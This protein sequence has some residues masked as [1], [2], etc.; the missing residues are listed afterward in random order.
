MEDSVDA[1]TDGDSVV[2][3]VSREQ[4]L[5]LA[6]SLNETIEAIEDWEFS[7]R[8][9]AGKDDARQLRAE[10]GSLITRLGPW[11]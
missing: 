10:L 11:E 9:G 1:W 3:S 8:L 4:L 5:L 2:L 7:T 6:G